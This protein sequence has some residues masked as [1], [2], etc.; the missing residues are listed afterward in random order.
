MVKS[1]QQKTFT[2]LKSSFMS[3]WNVKILQYK[4]LIWKGNCEYS[5]EQGI[6]KKWLEQCFFTAAE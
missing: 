1:H 3:K 5:I 4:Q 2:I 6:F